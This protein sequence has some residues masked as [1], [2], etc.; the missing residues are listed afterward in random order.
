MKTSY[1]R[2]SPIL[3][4][5]GDLLHS[6]G[7]KCHWVTSSRESQGKRKSLKLWGTIDSMSMTGTTMTDK[8]TKVGLTLPIYLVTQTDKVRGDIPRS[9][10]IRRAVEQYLKGKSGGGK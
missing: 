9:T 1:L 5:Y 4:G 7:I 3:V 6:Y 2:L 8:T 10:F